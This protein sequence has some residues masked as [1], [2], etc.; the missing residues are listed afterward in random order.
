VALGAIG[1]LMA[2]GG[3]AASWLPPLFPN[4]T[5]W[6][7][8]PTFFFVRLGVLMMAVPVAC[9]WASLWRGW[10]P[11]TELGVSSLFVYWVHVEIVYGVVSTPLHRALS[12]EQAVAAYVA[13]VFF[14][15]GLVR[16][17]GR[18]WPSP[19]RLASGTLVPSP[20]RTLAP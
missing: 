20:T 4:T 18:L 6:T 13:F 1:A 3:Y 14:L 17:K 9:A 15:Y 8:S 19:S 10:S 5:F 7:G 2:V 12:F 16:L 11:L